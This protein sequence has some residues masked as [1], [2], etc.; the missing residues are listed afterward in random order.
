MGLVAAALAGC[1]SH[2]FIRAAVLDE[3][4]EHARTVVS[5]P[6]GTSILLDALR[7]EDGEVHWIVEPQA[8]FPA[9]PGLALVVFARRDYFG[10]YDEWLGVGVTYSW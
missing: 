8:T 2:G 9:A 7:L 1:S 10:T 4:R 6:L 3:D 5:G